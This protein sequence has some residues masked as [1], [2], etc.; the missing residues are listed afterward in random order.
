MFVRRWKP[1]SSLSQ[2]ADQGVGAPG[3]RA[4]LSTR[5]GN[6]ERKL[7]CHHAR[8]RGGSS[9]RR[10]VSTRISNKRRTGKIAV[11]EGE[12][13]ARVRQKH[14]QV[15]LKDFCLPRT[16]PWEQRRAHFPL[17]NA[18]YFPRVL[19]GFRGYHDHRGSG[20]EAFC[21][22]FWSGRYLEIEGEK[23]S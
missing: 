14:R 18:C 9:R 21:V 1:R 22:R 11:G 15:P 19:L 10:V 13:V 5:V 23:P 4:R 6:A 3:R 16:V 20:G 2:A 8:L 12:P 7:T 17:P